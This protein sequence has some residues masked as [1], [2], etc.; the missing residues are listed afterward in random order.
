MAVF[1]IYLNFAGNT[2]EAFTFYKNALG[3]EI[4]M[5]QRF[6]DV[7]GMQ[8]S[9]ADM[10][11]IMHISLP[12]GN[13]NVLM[14]TDT[15]ESMGQK[16][17]QGNNFSILINVDSEAEADKLF[18]SLSAGGVVEMPLAKAFWGAYFGMFK[19]KFGI[20]WMINYEY[21]RN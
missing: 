12:L 5:I 1:N 7:P 6:K 15:L 17:N 9:E 16:L 18:A 14:G 19:D 11:K 20:Q 10:D 13:G 3:V 8:V 4:G 21:P 2:E